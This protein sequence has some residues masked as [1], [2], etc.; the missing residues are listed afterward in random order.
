MKFVHTTVCS[1]HY[2]DSVE[3]YRKVAGLRVVGEVKGHITFLADREGDTCVEVIDA[4]G[5]AFSG[6][7]ISVGFACRD[8]AKYREELASEGYEV[9][10]MVRPG[11]PVEFFFVKDPDGLDVQFIKE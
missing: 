10:D 3:F 8:P 7:G 6:S 5:K 4:P 2:A 1:A 9:T 11:G